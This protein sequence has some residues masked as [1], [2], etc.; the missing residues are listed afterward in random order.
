MPHA[1]FATPARLEPEIAAWQALLGTLQAEEQA[2]VA[3]DA[4][5]IAQLTP[6]KLNQLNEIGTHVRARQAAL[7][8]AGHPADAAGVTAWLGTTPE[9]K[10]R[11]QQLGEL[12]AAAQAANQ[13]VGAL[14]DMRLGTA[15]QAL[16]V[17]VHAA[18]RGNGL[19]DESGQSVAARFGKPI[20]AA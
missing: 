10:A 4:E 20:S 9:R 5:R 13:R 19:Y 12:E 14:L 17:L 3:G 16:N 8:A 18:T 11:W 1:D 7:T 2:L 15:R 6:V